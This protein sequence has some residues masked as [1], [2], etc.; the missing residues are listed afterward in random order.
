[1]VKLQEYLLDAPDASG[2]VDPLSLFSLFLK[3]TETVGRLVHTG[4]TFSY[5]SMDAEM[6]PGS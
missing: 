1:M 4:T 2:G 5:S 3:K 6:W